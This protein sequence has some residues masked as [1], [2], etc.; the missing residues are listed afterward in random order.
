M[1]AQ[2]GLDVRRKAA[3]HLDRA[4]VVERYRA[5]TRGSGRLHGRALALLPGGNTRA[6]VFYPPYPIYL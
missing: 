5:L 6:T 1:T 2:A 4:A 3:A